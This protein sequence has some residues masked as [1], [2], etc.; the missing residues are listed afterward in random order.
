MKKKFKKRIKEREKKIEGTE[1]MFHQK[2][3]IV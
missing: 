1:V 3:D 2:D